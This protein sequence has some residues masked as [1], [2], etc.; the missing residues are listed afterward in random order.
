[1]TV[2][3]ALVTRKLLLIAADL[4]ALRPVAARGLEAYLG[5]RIDQASW[6]VTWSEWSAA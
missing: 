1:M 5:N 6:N 2:D 3:P 4:D